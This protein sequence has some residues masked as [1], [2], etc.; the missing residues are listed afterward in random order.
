MK[1]FTI[2]ELSRSATA[3]ARGID[4]TPPSV[5]AEA[6]RALTDNVLDPLRQAWG[7][8]LTVTSGYQ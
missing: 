5:A 1:Y 6:L 2:D 8:P 4:N 3:T 7:R